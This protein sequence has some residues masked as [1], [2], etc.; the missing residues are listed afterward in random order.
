MPAAVVKRIKASR[1][2]EGSEAPVGEAGWPK[3]GVAEGDPVV[4]SNELKLPE[5][6]KVARSDGP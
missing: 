3:E 4:T 1:A 5:R 6:A 2:S